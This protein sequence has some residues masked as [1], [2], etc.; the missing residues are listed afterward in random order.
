[1]F[2]FFFVWMLKVGYGEV[3]GKKYKEIYFYWLC[4]FIYEGYEKMV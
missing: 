2:V 4:G 3:R 1:M